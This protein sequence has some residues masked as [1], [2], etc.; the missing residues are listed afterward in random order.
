MTGSTH[1]SGQ[2]PPQVHARSGARRNQILSAAAL[3]VT[4]AGIVLAV[5]QPPW[6]TGSLQDVVS[7]AGSAAP[8]L[9]V[10]LCVLASKGTQNIFGPRRIEGL[11]DGGCNWL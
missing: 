6:L 4:A 7:A 8:L 9:F 10:L 1:P 11:S 5:L 2:Q 3:G